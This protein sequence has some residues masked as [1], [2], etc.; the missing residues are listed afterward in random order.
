M[1]RD[2]LVKTYVDVQPYTSGK[3]AYAS[4]NIQDQNAPVPVFIKKDNEVSSLNNEKQ[5][6][7]PIAFNEQRNKPSF[8]AIAK[9]AKR[10]PVIR[11]AVQSEPPP[12]QE[13]PI[14]IKSTIQNDTPAVSLD[15]L[16]VAGLS[17]LDESEETI[18]SSEL[19]LQEE[20]PSEQSTV[21][22]NETILPSVKVPV[23][24]VTILWTLFN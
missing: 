9:S 13:E 18:A 17:L 24:S 4:L 12:P 8:P 15:N 21:K 6:P 16:M 23:L 7:L 22:K 2:T 11:S 20:S 3:K 19:F 1:E 14:I 10:L 5:P